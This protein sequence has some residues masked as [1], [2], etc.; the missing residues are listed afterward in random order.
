VVE[1]TPKTT[2]SLSL[3]SPISFSDALN[4]ARAASKTEKARE[5]DAPHAQATAASQPR[6]AEEDWDEEV[7]PGLS[8]LAIM[9]MLL[10]VRTLGYCRSAR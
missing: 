3:S 4:E 5:R 1:G 7:E 2:T 9:A 8:T 10:L 6:K